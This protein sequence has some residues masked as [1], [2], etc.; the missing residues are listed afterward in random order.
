MAFMS[1][2]IQTSQLIILFSHQSLN[3]TISKYHLDVI[4]LAKS[5][6]RLYHPVK[7]TV[8]SLAIK[9][10]LQKLNIHMKN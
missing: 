7:M 2:L 8:S 6:K 5:S 3:T 9:T 10:I 1:P 4:N